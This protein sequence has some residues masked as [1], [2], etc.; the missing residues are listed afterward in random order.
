FEGLAAFDDFAATLSG[1][2]EAQRVRAV[3]ASANFF[4]LLQVRPQLGRMPTPAEDQA[5]ATPLAILTDGLWYRLFGGSPSAIGQT[6][7]INGITFTIAGVLPQR[8]E[9]Q[10]VPGAEVWLTGDRGVPRSF[11][12]SGDI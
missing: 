7:V 1:Q 2:F 3:S 11:P 4:D 9:L 10:M 12:F 6:L 8:F 5:S